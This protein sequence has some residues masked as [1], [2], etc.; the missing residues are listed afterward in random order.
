MHKIEMR[1]SHF[2]QNCQILVCFEQKKKKILSRFF[3]VSKILYI[4]N[5]FKLS[6]G[7]PAE[8]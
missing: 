8:I 2:F 1:L 7:T 5:A 6:A 4:C 3:A